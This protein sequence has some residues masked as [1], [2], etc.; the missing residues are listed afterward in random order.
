MNF[1][2][3]KKC[4]F[5]LSLYVVTVYT[6]SVYIFFLPQCSD[7]TVNIVRSTWHYQFFPWASWKTISPVHFPAL[8]Y[9]FWLFYLFFVE[10]IFWIK[11]HRWR[12]RH[13]DC[14]WKINE[15]INSS[16]K[17]ALLFHKN[18]ASFF[19]RL[20]LQKQKGYVVLNR[21]LKKK[22]RKTQGCYPQKPIKTQSNEIRKVQKW[23]HCQ[24]R[25]LI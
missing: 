25:R 5:G 2:R 1:N 9:L 11:Q 12:L 21:N 24:T 22:N 18:P 23:K 4:K 15:Q 17:S 19:N 10:R 14:S 7:Y 13:C 8:C 6:A 3:L 16:L 20:V